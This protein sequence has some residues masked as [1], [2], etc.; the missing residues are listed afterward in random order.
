[1]GVTGKA[2]QK[3]ERVRERSLFSFSSLTAS[4]H[5]RST[6]QSESHIPCQFIF[7][8]GGENEPY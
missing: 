4:I 1:M 7:I 5:G 2:K 8:M 3:I 6:H